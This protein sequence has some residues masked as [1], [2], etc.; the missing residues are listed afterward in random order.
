VRS[1]A[2]EAVVR[3]ECRRASGRR[4]EAA[5]RKRQHS[6]GEERTLAPSIR[7]EPRFGMRN[8][9]GGATGSP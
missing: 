8:S 3:V 4:A 7:V 6:S 9:E 5:Q 2:R 1:D